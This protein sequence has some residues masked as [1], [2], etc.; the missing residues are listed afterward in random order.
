MKYYNFI[1]FFLI[2]NFISISQ[3]VANEF[4]FVAFAEVFTEENL[5]IKKKIED[6]ESIL[7]NILSNIQNQIIEKVNIQKEDNPDLRSLAQWYILVRETSAYQT[8]IIK[9]NHEDFILNSSYF[10]NK[11]AELN[12]YKNHTFEADTYNYLFSHLLHYLAN[13]IMNSKESDLWTV[14]NNGNQ[15]RNVNSKVIAYYSKSIQAL[16]QIS[17]LTLFDNELLFT[18]DGSILNPSGENIS[19]DD[20]YK[21][22]NLY[23]TN[24]A[25]LLSHYAY[26]D[27]KKEHRE[28]LKKIYVKIQNY[29]DYHY[30]TKDELFVSIFN[31]DEA[32]ILYIYSAEEYI[33]ILKNL[34][35]YIEKNLEVPI[36]QVDINTSLFQ[37]YY[38]I[39]DHSLAFK[40]FKE[41]V[42]EIDELSSASEVSLYLTFFY[43]QI[44]NKDLYADYLTLIEL[45]STRSITLIPYL[46]DSNQ[47]RAVQ[48]LY[49]IEKVYDLLM[50]DKSGHAFVEAAINLVKNKK[51]FSPE[52]L[53]FLKIEK[54]NEFFEHRLFEDEILDLKELSQ[55]YED[56][57][58]VSK[59]QIVLG[60]QT[61]PIISY[62]LSNIIIEYLELKK[63]EEAKYY[64]EELKTL[65]NGRMYTSTYASYCD[66][67][68]D[69]QCSLDNFKKSIEYTVD[70]YN[71]LK[72]TDRIVLA[73]SYTTVIADEYFALASMMEDAG[74]FDI[75]EV[76]QVQD[77]AIEYLIKGFEISNRMEGL[78]DASHQYEFLNNSRY[79]WIDSYLDNFFIIN[80]NPISL[81]KLGV[82]LSYKTKDENNEQP[83]KYIFN[84][85]TTETYAIVRVKHISKNSV[86]YEKG[87][88]KN[89]II[90]NIN[91][92]DLYAASIF[93]TA[94]YRNFENHISTFLNSNN[95]N[96][97]VFLKNNDNDKLSSV[98]NTNIIKIHINDEEKSNLPLDH[99]TIE[100]AFYIS[101][102][103]ISTDASTAIN[104]LTNRIILNKDQDPKLIK[105]RQDLK[106]QIKG[107]SHSLFL[108]I[109]SF[110]ENEVSIKRTE[111]KNLQQKLFTLDSFIINSSQENKVIN[112]RIYQ[113]DEVSNFLSSDELLIINFSFR[114]SNYA[115]GITS[116]GNLI[117]NKY[118]PLSEEIAF[119]FF[120][121]SHGNEQFRSVVDYKI[122]GREY[123]AKK[124][125]HPLVISDDVFVDFL[126]NSYSEGMYKM[127][128][129]PFSD[130]LV[131]VK[132][133]IFVSTGG[134]FSQIP[135]NLLK[136][137]SKTNYFG[138][139]FTTKHLVSL[140]SLEIDRIDQIKED[141]FMFL[142]VGHPYLGETTPNSKKNFDFAQLVQ[143]LFRGLE[144]ADRNILQK[145]EPL[146]ETENELLAISKNF[147]NSNIKLL[148]QK[149]A[150]ERTI[151]S[152]DLS[153]WDIINFSTHTINGYGLS[154]PGLILSLPDES[155]M[156]D[157]GV[158]L[159]SEIAQLNLNAELVVLSACNTAAGKDD[160]SEILSGLAQSFLY[161]GA[162]NLI[163]SHW[164]VED[165][166]TGILMSSFYNFWLNEKYEPAEALKLAQ[167]K[168]RNMPEYSHPVFWAG[169]SYYGL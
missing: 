73:S 29:P 80:S 40:I 36:R 32:P 152:M 160:E 162:K 59:N 34:K 69:V 9:D 106:K 2:F 130:V 22:I 117:F 123:F 96:S 133:V 33:N 146:P 37:L 139:E 49:E 62:F 103:L 116:T 119:G 7:P 1:L 85:Y 112:Q 87:L 98:D 113:L 79:F 92:Q 75:R 121:I 28:L 142:G 127:I 63:Y 83:I 53:I 100:R 122:Y 64:L 159:V 18:Y 148:L 151:R 6:D 141:N 48:L 65:E 95:E 61:K 72:N 46:K 118:Y 144:I 158:L 149:D 161:A 16:E 128:L 52:V 91:G 27:N 157:D 3:S 19:K 86:L 71:Q 21:I 60:S 124:Y 54:F 136:D 154:E 165:R 166:S 15:V 50:I 12:Y 89:D 74:G 5:K 42:P 41:I 155:T 24:S 78:L 55:L 114:N 120:G 88:R 56:W 82:E 25:F 101:Q 93:D 110:S 153:E 81:E 57:K 94:L 126:L 138:D 140:N 132:D 137:P 13:I 35:K 23:F 20:Y 38:E 129:E 97:I 67:I 51:T 17:Y 168:V 109:N 115:W 68:G 169:F 104:K 31:G 156:D 167:I 45:I 105:T 43:L 26:L 131:A 8:Q 135:Y 145:F 4:D 102:I 163:L 10:I 84:D 14:D 44:E 111:L 134:K 125:N 76:F 11:F 147:K 58:L 66:R 30:L 107:L 90:L 150:S 108:E 47:L 143:N 39:D 99:E 164:P 70:E 77:K